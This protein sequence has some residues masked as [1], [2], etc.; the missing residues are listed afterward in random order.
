MKI[1]V[2]GAAGFIGSHL[3]RSLLD[4]G[5]DV[6]MVDG[7]KQTTEEEVVYCR[8]RCSYFAIKPKML[9]LS[10]VHDFATVMDIRQND[11]DV[12]IHLAAK[13]GVRQSFEDPGSYI[14]NNI[15]GTQNLIDWVSLKWPKAKV[16]YASTS[17]VYSSIEEYPWSEDMM[18]PHMKNPYGYSKYVNE[19]QFKISGLNAIGMRFFTVYG[20]YGRLDMAPMIFL[21]NIYN[22]ERMQMFND[23]D[24]V[25]DF[26]YI[27]DIVD[28]IKLLMESDCD[29][30]IYNIGCEDPVKLMDFVNCLVGT[31]GPR[32]CEFDK[33]PR[34]P[35]DPIVTYSDCTKLKGLGYSPRVNYDEGIA[36]LVEWFD[37]NMVD[38]S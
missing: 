26:T 37:N 14:S 18:L 9:D 12:V 33:V 13:A 29:E 6:I 21:N 35:A 7:F 24:M 34:H 28:G 10:K 25:R 5:H 23:G 16:L 11:V 22:G 19:C 27:D 3:S 30:D 20:P 17:N 36:R 38:P 15:I 1:L 2:T 32:R 31:S 4:D 8:R